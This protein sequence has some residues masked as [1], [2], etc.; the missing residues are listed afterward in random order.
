MWSQIVS[1]LI[2]LIVVTYVIQFFLPRTRGG[3]SRTSARWDLAPLIGFCAVILLALSFLEALRRVMIEA[4]LIGIACGVVAGA[5]LWVAL[6]ARA[7][8]LPRQ[9]GSAIVATIRAIRAF[10]LPVLFTLIGVYL[11]IRFIGALVELFIAGLL[12]AIILALAVWLFLAS[13]QTKTG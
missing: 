13:P 6:G 10:G 11:A 9:S 12:G 7:D 2:V 4:W 1:A 5:L 8:L 3:A